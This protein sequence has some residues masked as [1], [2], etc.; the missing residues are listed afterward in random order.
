MLSR[1]AVLFYAASGVGKSSLV[2]AGLIPKLLGGERGL[3]CEVL[4]VVRVSGATGSGATGC[5]ANE[6]VFTKSILGQLKDRIGYSTLLDYLKDKYA[7]DGHVAA[8]RRQS[9]FSSS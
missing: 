2:N 4:G 3:D 8:R 1:R 9:S 7:K 6:N 5:G